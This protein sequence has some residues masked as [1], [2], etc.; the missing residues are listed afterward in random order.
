MPQTLRLFGRRSFRRESVKASTKTL[1]SSTVLPYSNSHLTDSCEVLLTGIPAS[2]DLLRNIVLKKLLS[3]MGLDD[4]ERFIVSSRDWSPKRRGPDA[5]ADFKAIVFRCSSPSNRDFFIM[6][7]PKLASIHTETIFGSGGSHRLSL[8]AL[9]PREVYS[10]L[11]KANTA[12]HGIGLTRPIVRNLTV[13]M[14]KIVQSPLIPIA[15]IN[16]LDLFVAKNR[17]LSQNQ[18]QK[19]NPNQKK[20][21]LVHSKHMI[22]AD[23]LQIYHSFL[24]HH[25]DIGIL[26]LNRDMA[27]VAAWAA[28]NGLNLNAQK[29]KATILASDPYY[30][31]INRQ[32]I[33]QL[34][35]NSV[36]IP[37]STEVKCLGLWIEKDLSWSKQ[38]G[39]IAGWIHGVLR[40]LRCHRRTLSSRYLSSSPPTVCC[41]ALLSG[42]SAT[43]SEI[44]RGR[45]AKDIARTRL[46]SRSTKLDALRCVDEGDTAAEHIETRDTGPPLTMPV[47][48]ESILEAILRIEAG[49]SEVRTTCT[50]L[51]AGAVAMDA[52]LDKA[53]ATLDVHDGR[54]SAVEERQREIMGYMKRMKPCTGVKIV[55]IPAALS[56]T[57]DAGI[58][59]LCVDVLK[60]FG[61]EDTINDVDSVRWLNPPASRRAAGGGAA[62]VPPTSRTLVVEYKQ[63]ITRDRVLSMK[64]E[65]GEILASALLPGAS[66]VLRMYEMHSKFTHNLLLKTKELASARGYAHVWVR[67]GLVCVRK[68]DGSEVIEVLTE[69]DLKSLL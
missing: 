68:S 64:K 36:V 43:A 54:I 22:F 65:A 58:R 60:L 42:A 4:F 62:A 20:N 44:R 8:C 59:K 52:K 11:S 35:L 57:S 18:N 24:P 17:T 12:A 28:T 46:E 33:P 47:T 29:T 63:S 55:G 45:R 38:V 53:I 16:E 40:V 41:A 13:H 32:P 48:N 56:D 31:L 3:A 21:V 14:R 23:D 26:R 19:Q 30:R 2:V 1:R 9:W 50:E 6:S 66:G 27:A 15:T 7:A 39:V 37:Y 51:K 10:L 69:M 61:A 49:V 5:P 25:L 34:S 67:D